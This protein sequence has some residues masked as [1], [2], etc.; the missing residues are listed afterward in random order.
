MSNPMPQKT[1][2]IDASRANRLQRT[3]VEW[4]AY[5]LIQRLK[6][7]I[8]AEY[9]VILYTEEP[10]RDGLEQLPANWASEVL[11]WP[12]KGRFRMWSQLRLSWEMLVHAPDLLFIPA[13]MPPMLSPRRM[14]VTL[15]DAAFI[16]M[17]EAYTFLGRMYNWLM[18]W[19]AIISST[20]LTVSDFSKSEL[21]RLFR[22]LARFEDIHVTRLG[23]DAARFHDIEEEE[24]AFRLKKNGISKPYFL[25]VGRLET[26]KNL[27]GLLKA[28]RAYRQSRPTE[29]TSLVLVGKPGCGYERD[30]LAL[31]DDIRP[32]VQQLGYVAPEDMPAIY[33]GA[34]ALTFVSLFEGFGIP[35]L[36]AF[37]C[38]TPVIGS[39][40]TSFPEV[41]GDAALLVNPTDPAA[42]AQA[43][44][45][46]MDDAGLRAD[47]RAKGHARVAEF[48]WEKCA[49]QT[50]AVIE[51]ML[52]K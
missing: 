22:P 40:G 17:P 12:I 8:P 26:K 32:Y 2:A 29:A 18:Y 4:Y 25:F 9:K 5:H 30:I 13:S 37:A 7:V 19:V 6:T 21:L 35:M 15:H 14:L 46:V 44:A 24:I 1:I 49:L 34:T 16:T 11:E 51:K 33:A 27:A 39:D 50:W 41:A 38:G 47:L 31:T 52:Q 28:F 20:V 36:E 42:V 3:G 23:F 43:M 45:R 48:S 10:L